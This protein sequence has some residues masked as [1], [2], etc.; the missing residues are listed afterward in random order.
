M[1]GSAVSLLRGNACLI[2]DL[3]AGT[4]TPGQSLNHPDLPSGG[5]IEGR[6]GFVLQVLKRV[7]IEKAKAALS[8]DRWEWVDDKAA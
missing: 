4:W 6:A 2:E 5:W 3:Q 7:G 8:E 1:W